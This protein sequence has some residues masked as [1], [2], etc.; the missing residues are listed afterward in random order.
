MM[1]SKIKAIIEEGRCI[2]N[3]VTDRRVYYLVIS[4]KEDK[5]K[6]SKDLI[7][8]YEQ[9]EIAEGKI[10]GHRVSYDIDKD[11]W[12]CDCRGF[13]F[14]GNCSHIESSK[15]METKLAKEVKE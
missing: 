14:H 12:I 11:T 13:V 2:P 7:E 3:L 9:V 6:L 8:A 5:E 10:K 15:A 4:N 1:E